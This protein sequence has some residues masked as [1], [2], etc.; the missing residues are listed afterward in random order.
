[1]YSSTPSLKPCSSSCS[2]PLA[3]SMRIGTWEYFRIVFS[4][5]QP[6]IFGIITSKRI[7]AISFCSKKM[8]IASSP[9]PASTTWKPLTVRKSFTSFLILGSSSTT[10]ILSVS[11][12]V[13]LCFLNPVL[14]FTLCHFYGSILTDYKKHFHHFTDISL[15]TPFRRAGMA[16]REVIRNPKL[17]EARL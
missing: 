9:S 17:Q 10:N 1:M 8:S 6:S 12:S 2:S 11:I 13:R 14:L 16:E 15:F 4:T 5:S 3:V 7:K